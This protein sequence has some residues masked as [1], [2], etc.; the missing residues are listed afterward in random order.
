[1]S[2]QIKSFWFAGT[3]FQ[4]TNVMSILSLAKIPKY[5]L[6]FFLWG[7][8]TFLVLGSTW[9]SGLSTPTGLVANDLS[10]VDFLVFFDVDDEATNDS[11]VVMCL[12]KNNNNY[13]Q[14]KNILSYVIEIMKASKYKTNYIIQC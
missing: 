2:S 6:N 9:T 14:L 13:T 3:S 8:L 12:L 4:L 1:M 5:I 10:R 11:G 7:P